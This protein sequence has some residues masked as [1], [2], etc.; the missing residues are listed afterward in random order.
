MQEIFSIG[1][2]EVFSK[3]NENENSILTQAIHRVRTKLEDP[4]DF[5]NEPQQGT[6]SQAVSSSNCLVQA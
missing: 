6:H 1:T 3:D 4:V 2:D 5:R